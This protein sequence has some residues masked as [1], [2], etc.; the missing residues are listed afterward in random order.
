MFKIFLENIL[1][2]IVLLNPISK[3]ILL[4]SMESEITVEKLVQVS[5]QATVTA[6]SILIIFAFMG[7]F[8]LNTLFRIE[9]SSLRVVGGIVLFMVGLRALQKGEFFNSLDK[10]RTEDMV[11][12]PIASPLIAGPATIA[13]AISQS[14]LINPY[15][16]SLAII[17][18]SLINYLV[19]IFSFRISRVL[20][21]LHLINPLIRIT[22]LL[23]ASLGMDMVM[24]G[25][26][27]FFTGIN[28]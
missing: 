5:R 28:L 1:I 12:V 23:I 3:V 20:R 13:A 7:L 21:A 15:I 19:M 10:P 17:V 11:V 2:F 24:S 26:K 27:A 25:I 8:I 22:G 14:A 6:V 9:Y 18:A 16:V 4:A